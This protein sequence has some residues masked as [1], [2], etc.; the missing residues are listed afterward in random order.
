MIDKSIR[1]RQIAAQ[2]GVSASTVSRA[3]NSPDAVKADTRQRVYTAM[4][5][6]GIPYDTSTQTRRQRTKQHANQKSD[7]I[8]LNLPAF[9][10]PF[11]YDI[12]KGARE[13]VA[14]RGM[15]IITFFS[16]ISERNLQEVLNVI[17]TTQVQGII[18]L[19]TMDVSTIKAITARIPLVQCSEY[20]EAIP[21]SYVSVDDRLAAKNATEYIL[22]TGHNKI[23]FMNSQPRFRFSRY[24]YDGFREALDQAQIT[25]PNNWILHLPNAEYETA[26]A[27][28]MQLLS[29]NSIPNAI[30]AVSDIYAVA[31]LNV[32]KDLNYRVPEDLIIVGF[33]DVDISR[34]SSPAITTVSMPRYQM[35]YLA[36]EMLIEKILSSGEE[37]KQILLNARLVIRGSSSPVNTD[38]IIVTNVRRPL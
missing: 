11:F 37:E 22:S 32:A 6:L 3:L 12:Y 23:A 26:Y 15:N 21:T 30:F 24:R 36:G 31:A 8:M 10:N 2:A 29:G 5:Q 38:R 28:V 1:I 13:A 9:N 17:E 4:D 25:V 18:S 34:I 27:A 20:N 35:G 16:P 7:V 14:A 33:D 19:C